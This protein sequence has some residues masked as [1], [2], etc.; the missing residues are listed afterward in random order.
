MVRRRTCAVSNH[1]AT[2]SHPSRRGREAAPPAMSATRSRGDEDRCHISVAEP[3][4]VHEIAVGLPVGCDGVGG[5]AV[6]GI[7]HRDAGHDD[8]ILGNV[9]DLAHDIRSGY[10]L[11]VD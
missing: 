2:Y 11:A 5:E 10:S 1:E 8:L 7:S 6:V 9:C 4:I 3:H